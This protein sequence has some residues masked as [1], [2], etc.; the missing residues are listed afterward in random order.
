MAVFSKK[1]KLPR[2]SAI[3]VAAGTANRMEGADKQLLMLGG[4]P[5]V[6]RSLSALGMCERVFEIVV[7][8][9]EAQIADYYDLV[10]FYG[11][12]KVTSVV[13]GGAVR[14]DSVFAGIGACSEDTEYF[15]IH[16]GARPLVLP[17]EIDACIDL[18]IE[19]KAAAVGVKVKDT[20]KICDGNGVI[21]STPHRDSLWAIQTPQIFEAN[22]YRRAMAAAIHGK[23]EYTDDCQLIENFGHDVRISQGSHENIKITMPPDIAVAEAI[24]AMREGVSPVWQD[25][26]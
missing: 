12:D 7:V 20:I 3:V 26:A 18:A 16:D 14:Q 21:I 24:I 15:A 6:T 8:C 9:R 11:F 22:L 19:T 17:E 23:R 4:V 2:V 13:A 25:F 5:V 1:Q 10:R